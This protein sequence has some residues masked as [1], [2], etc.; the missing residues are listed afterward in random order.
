MTSEY[1]DEDRKKM[2]S[3]HCK[4]LIGQLEERL[5]TLIIYEEMDI[6]KEILD[7]R[8]EIQKYKN[9]LKEIEGEGNYEP[10]KEKESS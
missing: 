1:A 4:L 5:K 9:L 2:V 6:R 8:N 7:I 3:F 10:I